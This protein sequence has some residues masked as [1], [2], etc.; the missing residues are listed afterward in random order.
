MGLRCLGGEG[1][2]RNLGEG[3]GDVDSLWPS[4]SV[5]DVDGKLIQREDP[6]EPGQAFPEGG[7]AKKALLFPVG[8]RGL[9]KTFEGNIGGKHEIRNRVGP[10]L[11][12]ERKT[13]SKRDALEDVFFLFE[14]VVAPVFVQ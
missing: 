13:V 9:E 5:G 10:I 8:K 3:R 7:E 14:I 12:I 1:G 2:L 4:R 6:G 11:I